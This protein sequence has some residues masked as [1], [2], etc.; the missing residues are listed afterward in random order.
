MSRALD[1]F[2]SISGI[3]LRELENYLFFL[4]LVCETELFFFKLSKKQAEIKYVEPAEVVVLMS[5]AIREQKI[6][7]YI[8]HLR[9]KQMTFPVVFTSHV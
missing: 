4:L 2:K 3:V 7:N 1:S 9:L 5:K 8:R 6:G